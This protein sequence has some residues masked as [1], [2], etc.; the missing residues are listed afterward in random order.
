MATLLTARDLFS[1]EAALTGESF[2]AEKSPEV[3][4]A[5]TPLARRTNALFLDPN[6]PVQI[7]DGL[8]KY[9]ARKGVSDISEIIGTLKPPAPHD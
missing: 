5:D 9:L 8:T 3:L 4:P 1:N 6:I 7:I 2:P